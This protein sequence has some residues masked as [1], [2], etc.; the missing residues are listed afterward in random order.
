M[1][2]K[3][4]NTAAGS[5]R[6]RSKTTSSTKPTRQTAPHKPTPG[7]AA[8]PATAAQAKPTTEAKPANKPA[9]TGNSDKKAATAAQGALP[10]NIKMPDPVELSHSVARIAE[11]SQRLIMDF[12]ERRAGAEHKTALDPLNIGSAF[13]ELT[14]RM[15]ADPSYLM[16]AQFNLWQSYIDLWQYTTKRMMG[17]TSEPVASP[18][19]GDRRFKDQEWQDNAVFDYIKQSYLLTARWLQDTVAKVE[20]IDPKQRRKIDFYTRQ[21]VDALAP[22]NFATTN[23]EVIRST[24]ETGGENLVRGLEN[25][26]RDLERGEGDLVVTMTDQEAFKVGENLAITPG[27]VIYENPLAQLIQYTPT[28]ETV[29]RTPLLILPPWINKFY[30]LD[31]KPENSFIRWA[32]EQGHT[33]FVVSWV[34]PDDS[35]ADKSF[36]DYMRLGIFDMLEQIEKQ[37][38][39]QQVNAVGYCLGGTLLSST[40]AVM[41]RRGTDERIKSATFFTTLTDFEESGE[42]AVFV[43]EEQ[44]KHLQDRMAD[45]GYF[46]ALDMQRVFNLLRA[47]DLIWSFVV[48]NYLLGKDPFPFDLLFWNSDSTR[49]PAAM[50]LFY[51]Q[52]MYQQNKL[53]QP[54]GITLDGTPV[55]LRK[56]RTPAYMLSTREDHIAPWYSTYRATGVFSGSTDF[57]LAASGHIAGVVNA[58]AKHKYCYWTNEQRPASSDEWMAGATQ[59][60][61]SWWPHWGEWIKQ[62]GGEQVPARDPVHGKFKIIEDAPGRYVLER[63]I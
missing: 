15:M 10:A 31:L 14:Q 39:E 16:K 44:L 35:L 51:L 25:L 52:N 36:E 5:R 11:R 56:V 41:A 32:L 58:P 7:K 38:G 9:A 54:D 48:N 22:S 23:P 27:K 6:P 24:L 2:E 28:T 20:G 12:M 63:A 61:G 8:K 30:I 3:S 21:F 19:K 45:S 33:V 26:L 55:D 53:I 1:V 37:T 60:E 18:P 17:E 40:L 59:H 29:Y 46:D 57:V 13:I 50:H 34:N 42:V 4:P 43:D 49:L 62:F 47:N